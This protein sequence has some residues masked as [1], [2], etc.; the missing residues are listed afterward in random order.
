M[1]LHNLRTKFHI[2]FNQYNRTSSHFVMTVIAASVAQGPCFNL[3]ATLYCL[4]FHLFEYSFPC[5]LYI[6]F[7]PSSFFLSFHIYP[8]FLFQISPCQLVSTVLISWRRGRNFYLDVSLYYFCFHVILPECGYFL[9]L[10][11]LA[12][13]GHSLLQRHD[14]PLPGCSHL[15]AK[16]GENKYPRHIVFHQSDRHVKK[17]EF[18]YGRYWLFY[19]PSQNIFFT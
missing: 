8:F 13:F 9:V 12:E 10:E 11:E 6:F 17:Y 19:V 14:G 2:N 18:E 7:N 15:H 4:H 16:I 5:T 3:S 1:M